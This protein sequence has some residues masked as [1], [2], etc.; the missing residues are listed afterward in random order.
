MG[1]LRGALVLLGAMTASGQEG[2]VVGVSLHASD[3]VAAVYVSRCV[4]Q[5]GASFL[6]TCHRKHMPQIFAVCMQMSFVVFRNTT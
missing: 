4:K 3:R 2:G 5:E 1:E 6:S